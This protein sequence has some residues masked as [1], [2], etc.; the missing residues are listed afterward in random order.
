MA[1]LLAICSSVIFGVADFF[2]GMSAR[3]IAPVLTSAVAQ[4]TGL[5]V[6]A[7]GVAL[8]GGSPTARDLAL[9]VA[10]G[11]VGALALSAFYFGLATGSMSV[12]APASAVTSAIVAVMAGLALGES[13]EP[14]TW[15]GV[16]IALPAIILIAREGTADPDVQDEEPLEERTSRRAGRLGLA[17]GLAA[18]AGFGLF[19][20]LI[21]RTSDASG[22]WPLVTARSVASALLVGTVLVTRTPVAVGRNAG[23]AFALLAGALDGGSNILILEA[24]RRGLLVIVGVILAL[25]PASTIVLARVVLKERLQRHQLVGLGLAGAAVVLIAL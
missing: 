20:V 13:L 16:A 17:A 18:G 7:V 12:V 11:V 23:T 3:R 19:V 14:V 4:V 24:G 10:T 1:A 6:L 8:A 21:T 2:G 25:Y 9:G 15:L 5:V 22:L